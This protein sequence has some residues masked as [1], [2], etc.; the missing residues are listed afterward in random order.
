[1][2]GEV[3]CLTRAMARRG[4]WRWHALIAFGFAATLI[5]QTGCHRGNSRVEGPLSLSALK[6]L[7]T[8]IDLPLSATNILYAQA[9]VGLGGRARLYRFS[10]P[11]EDCLRYAQQLVSLNDGRNPAPGANIETGLTKLETRPTPLSADTLKA[12]GLE[13]VNWFSIDA[14]TNGYSGSGPPDGR[15][16]TWVDMGSG[17]FYYFWTD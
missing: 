17:I 15:G 14:I 16:L 3:E 8:G 2:Y 9:T 12:Y 11:P 1:M 10:A 7:G 5:L 13:A 6:A 4:V